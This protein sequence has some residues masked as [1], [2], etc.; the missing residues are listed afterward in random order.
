MISISFGGQCDSVIQ[1]RKGGGG[2]I[3][4]IGDVQKQEI[5]CHWS[6]ELLLSY[7]PTSFTPSMRLLIG[8]NPGLYHTNQDYQTMIASME[9]NLV[10]RLQVA[11]VLNS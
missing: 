4:A 5:E 1:T 3:M 2:F 9:G 6:R 10:S 7:V 8:S 11:G